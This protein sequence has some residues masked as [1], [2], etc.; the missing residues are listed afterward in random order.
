M[1]AEVWRTMNFTLLRH[2]HFCNV[3]VLLTLVLTLV[4]CAGGPR[5]TPVTR[6]EENKREVTTSEKGVTVPKKS[7]ELDANAIADFDAAMK[8][9]KAGEYEKGTDLLKKVTQ[10]APEHTVSYINL[11]MAYQKMDKLEAAEKSIK[12]ALEL[13]P[14][15]PVANT[16]YGVILRKA[17]KFTEA[18][19]VYERILT[20]YPA[21]LPARKNLGILCDIYLRDLECALT[22]YRLY[23]A[24]VPDN[25]KV[26]IWIAD[27]ERQVQ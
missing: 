8:H 24:A 5:T 11:A 10:R 2:S 16:E 23:S 19:E 20:Q 18:R 15:H 25:E 1:D 4:G 22:H 6:A 26:K 9:L 27:L 7:V 12:K 17:G 13:E 14:E 3:T 21:F